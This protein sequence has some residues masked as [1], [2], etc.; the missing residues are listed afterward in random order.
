MSDIKM[1]SVEEAVAA[2]AA[3]KLVIVVDDEDRENEGDFIFAASL[4]TPETVAFLLEHAS[5]YICVALDE[6]R[7]DHLELPLMV[8]NNTARLGTAM[9]VTV[10]ALEGTTTGISSFDRATTINKLADETAVPK[11]FARP[12]HIQPLRAVNGGVLKRKGHTEAGV[13]LVRLAGLPPVAGVVEV[14]SADKLRMARLPELSQLSKQHNIPLISIDQLIQHRLRTEMLVKRTSEARLP[15]A[16]GEFRC[17][18]FHDEVDGET[19]LALIAGNPEGKDNVLVRVHSECLTGDVFGSRR[20]DCGEQLTNSLELIASDPN[21]GV[22]IY[23]RGHE[24]RGVGLAHKLAAYVLQEQG[25]DTVDANLELGLPVDKREYA[26]AGQMLKNLSISNIRL[27][28]N[29]PAK[30]SA[31]ESMEIVVKERIPLRSVPNPDNIGYLRA[32]A[33][34]MGHLLHDLDLEQLNGVLP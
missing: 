9:T 22:V 20:C 32:K 26:I 17:A 10:D 4:A 25:L 12:G 3:G 30:Q 28:T 16:F 23:M 2:I 19:H 8:E 14:I 13:D 18:A 33:E 15:S 24:G 21:G 11:D 6:Q 29:N 31:L 5:G 1:S 34:R 7:A 27:L